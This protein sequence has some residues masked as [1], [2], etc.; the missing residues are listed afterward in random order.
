[1]RKV[2][3]TFLIL[4]FISFAP[5]LLKEREPI[6]LKNITEKLE[7][8]GLLANERTL[9]ITDRDYYKKGE[10]IWSRVYLTNGL[11]NQQKPL[12]GVIY[13]ELLDEDG[14][15]VDKRKLKVSDY[16]AFGDLFIK[17]EWDSGT[18]YLRAFT[19][20]MLNNDTPRSQMKPIYIGVSDRSPHFV[21]D[22]NT[23]TSIMIEQE[24]GALVHNVMSTI[25]IKGINSDGEMLGE[26]GEIL[27][28]QD[29]VVTSFKL[30]S[31]GY[32]KAH[33]LPQFGHDYRLVISS[34]SDTFEKE[35]PKVQR[36]GFSL[37]IKESDDHILVNMTNTGENGLKGCFLL[38]HSGEKTLDV[39]SLGETSEENAK[40]LKISKKNMGDGFVSFSLFDKNGTVQ[41]QRSV[42]LD[43]SKTENLDLELKHTVLKKGDSIQLNIK[44]GVGTK[45]E[46]SLA[47]VSANRI[48]KN[49]GS[50]DV[51]AIKNPFRTSEVLSN[52]YLNEPIKRKEVLDAI[53]ILDSSKVVDWETVRGF[54]VRDINYA[55]ELG[56]MISGRI[57]NKNRNAAD[58]TKAMLTVAGAKPFQ[59]IGQINNNGTFEFGPYMFFD[60][61]NVIIHAKN[62]KL[63]DLDGK[64]V[65]IDV[66]NEW[67]KFTASKGSETSDAKNN[68]ALNPT[69]NGSVTNLKSNRLDTMEN[70]TVL[71][72]VVVSSDK[73]LK[74]KELNKELDKLTPY[75]VY[76]HRIVADSTNFRY[77]A[78]SALD[79]L[80]AVPGVLIR[81][82]FP[83]QRIVIRGVGTINESNSPLFLYNGVPVS[84]IAVEQMLAEEIMFVDVLKGGRTAAFGA[85]GGNGVVAFYSKRG[86]STKKLGKNHSTN[87]VNTNIPGFS[88]SRLYNELKVSKEKGENSPLLYW[89]PS[90][91]TSKDSLIQ[92]DT[93]GAT[94]TYMV[95]LHGL[96]KN[97]NPVRSRKIFEIKE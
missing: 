94:G 38:T 31:P 34:G 46:V 60:S 1:M 2:L 66:F 49:E 97:G 91:K 53:M 62:Q 19:K 83:N 48:N 25:A 67:P 10:R 54:N 56:I 59:E 3:F 39:Y 29:N 33:F 90:L 8:Y 32:G 70:V 9:I 75:L 86:R 35:L 80:Y 58:K 42:F 96:D 45:G 95:E 47:V 78:I 84:Q 73:A 82:S 36:E 23:P 57:K 27:D 40:L 76:D 50:E 14:K 71:D 89:N 68:P 72:E 65:S 7:N 61:L 37:R 77:G 16:G 21:E 63:D 81:G 26:T 52:L 18:Y 43:N 85:R 22:F 6:S 69:D 64:E 51:F 12:S 20:L 87:W 41:S 24:G 28:E 15:L 74:W 55:P 17:N 5:P 30:I 11:S 92:I 79:L 88:R 4:A 44:N 13:L 93:K